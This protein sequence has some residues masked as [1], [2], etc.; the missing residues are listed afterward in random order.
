MTENEL[1][2]VEEHG[3]R[4]EAVAQLAA[5]RETGAVNMHNMNGVRHVAASIGF[6]EL[7]ALL[8]D[9]DDH[10]RNERA[11]AYMAYLEHMA[12]VDDR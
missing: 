1:E 3:Y 12:E 9:L 11:E 5:V 4:R 6:D 8:D 2:L 7:V 10:P